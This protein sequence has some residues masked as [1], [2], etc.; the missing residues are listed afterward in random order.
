[1]GYTTVRASPGAVSA[2][3]RLAQGAQAAG[4]LPQ[5]LCDALGLLVDQVAGEA[6]VWEPDVCARA[7]LQAQGDVARAVSLVR[8]WAAMLPRLASTR[9]AL[10]SMRTMRRITP[11]FREPD[12]GQYLGA[13]LDYAQ[14]LLDLDDPGTPPGKVNGAPTAVINGAHRTTAP[15]PDDFPRALDELE[16]AGRVDPGPIAHP[17]DR[18][19]ESVEVGAERGAFAQLLSRAETG[20]M[21][22]LAYTALRGDGDHPTLAELRV[23]ELAVE[24]V[25]PRSGETVRVG[26]VPVTVAEMVLY[27]GHRGGGER[28][29]TLGVGA[30]FGRLERRAIAAALLDANCA[31]AG[32]ATV[33]RPPAADEEFLTIALEGQEAS[34][35]LEHLKLPHHVTFTSTLDRLEADGVDDGVQL[36]EDP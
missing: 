18:T 34:G 29:L 13:S 4:V 30:T 23:G 16:R 10:S 33:E 9:T 8:A 24:V 21:T 1:M 32:D 26:A 35:F 14:R 3:A 25:H 6:G 36:A 7:L 15:I 5:Q 28:R 31:A 27:R 19:R 20:T 22:A 2:A 11:A 17:L 12:G